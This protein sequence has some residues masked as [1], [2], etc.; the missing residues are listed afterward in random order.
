MTLLE[1]IKRALV[2]LGED[3]DEETV[4]EYKE[5]FAIT[6]HVNTGYMQ[7][8]ERDYKPCRVEQAALDERG[9]FSPESLG[10]AVLFIEGVFPEGEAGRVPPLA[11]CALPDGRV[12]VLN[13]GEVPVDVVYRYLPPALEEDTDVPVFPERFHD[14]LSDYAAYRVMGTGS[15][16]R[17]RRGQFFLEEFERKRRMIRPFGYE[18]GGVYA[19]ALKN[20]Y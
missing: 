2:H 6:G 17:Q 7:V 5:G 10:F 8:C 12:R 20:K 13:A 4:A 19:A 9:C 16:V 18:L 3:P 14:C 15:A 1:I 11:H